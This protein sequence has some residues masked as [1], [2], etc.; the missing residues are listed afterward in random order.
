MKDVMVA[1]EHVHHLAENIKNARKY[2][3]EDG[4]HNLHLKYYKEFNQLVQDFILE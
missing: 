2:I 4:K 1:E 3:W